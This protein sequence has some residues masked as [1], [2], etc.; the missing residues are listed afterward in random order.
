[1]RILF[2]ITGHFNIVIAI[3]NI[4][5]SVHVEALVQMLYWICGSFH[6]IVFLFYQKNS[7]ELFCPLGHE[8]IQAELTNTQPNNLLTSIKDYCEWNSNA[9]K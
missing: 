1:M 2:E 7:N 9:V 5:T 6:R 8:N 4:I 3:T